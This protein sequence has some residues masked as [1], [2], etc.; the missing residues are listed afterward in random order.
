MPFRNSWIL[1]PLL[2]RPVLMTRTVA[3]FQWCDSPPEKRFNA[4]L[5]NA[6][7]TLTEDDSG[8]IFRGV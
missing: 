6:Y 5:T 2:A 4:V 7:V 3:N 1:L 8:E